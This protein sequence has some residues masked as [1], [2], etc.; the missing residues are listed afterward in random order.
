MHLR[1][2][3]LATDG[4]TRDVSTADGDRQKT[5]SREPAHPA[6]AAAAEPPA[7]ESASNADEPAR[8]SAVPPETRPSLASQ[9]GNY[10]AP[11]YV[12]RKLEEFAARLPAAASAAQPKSMPEVIA[13]LLNEPTRSIRPPFRLPLPDA[14]P[15]RSDP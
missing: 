7:D 5:N 2:P 1:P 8:P 3:V 10:G 13:Q 4:D 14:S 15:R 11:P 9:Q 6:L 12:K